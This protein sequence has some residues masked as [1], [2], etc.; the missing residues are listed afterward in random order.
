MTSLQVF[1]TPFTWTRSPADGGSIPFLPSLP[2]GPS[3][4]YYCDPC[5]T[6]YVLLTYPHYVTV[7]LAFK[8]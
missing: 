5:V 6:D 3:Q 8:N 7:T 4:R 1:K 2:L